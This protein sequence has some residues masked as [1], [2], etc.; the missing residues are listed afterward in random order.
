MSAVLFAGCLTGC[1]TT[2]PTTG[3]K[4]FDP[5]KT[6]AA[7]DTIQPIAASSVRRVITNSPQHSDAIADYFRSIGT[8]FCKMEAT[9]NFSPQQLV[10][11]ADAATAKLQAG[12]DP[13]V[14][15]LKNAIVALYKLN[16]GA[17]FNAELPPD[18]WPAFVA[19]VFCQGISQGLKD[20][21]KPGVL[22]I[23]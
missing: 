18:K 4:K 1:T 10:D 7:K 12:V 8:A 15:D 19:S 22:G 17:R 5:V 13:F 9:G 3:E 14:I 2:D 16:F 6:Q 23:P 11:A 20:A 21:G